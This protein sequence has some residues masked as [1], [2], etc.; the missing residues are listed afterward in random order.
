MEEGDRGR[1]NE[2]EKEESNEGEEGTKTEK[3]IYRLQWRVVENSYDGRRREEGRHLKIFLILLF[4][5]KND[6]VSILLV[7][8]RK[9]NEGTKMK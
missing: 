9:T 4:L 3:Q 2:G 1:R 7:F 6:H 5:T 8:N